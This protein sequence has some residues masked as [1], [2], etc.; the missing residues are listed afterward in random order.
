VRCTPPHNSYIQAGAET[1]VTG[2]VLW[3]SVIFGGVISLRRWGK[4]LPRRFR[5]GTEEQK[6]LYY[7]CQYIPVALVGFAVSSY[8]LTFAWLEPYYMLLALT[9]GTIQL[10]TQERARVLHRARRARA[11]RM[12]IRAASARIPLPAPVVAD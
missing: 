10:A 12:A 5:N 6:F 11:T 2:L 3:S 8:F 4:K 7:S 1:G 9:A